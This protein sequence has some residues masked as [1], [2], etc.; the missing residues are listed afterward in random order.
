MENFRSN[1]PRVELVMD[2]MYM[3]LPENPFEG[4][5]N[6]PH[7]SFTLVTIAI[8]EDTN[9]GV[10]VCI[11]RPYTFVMVAHDDKTAVAFGKVNW[12]DKF[13]FNSGFAIVARKAIAAYYRE[14]K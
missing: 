14:T 9:W 13:S 10:D 3:A 7:F 8:G 11:K 12:T 6:H 1:D 4:A 2:Q 5:E